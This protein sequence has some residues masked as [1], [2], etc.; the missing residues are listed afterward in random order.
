MN[1]QSTKIDLSELAWRYSGEMEVDLTTIEYSITGNDQSP[2]GAWVQSR[3]P[4]EISGDLIWSKTK[5]EVD[6]ELELLYTLGGNQAQV[7]CI[8]GKFNGS[9]IAPAMANTYSFEVSLRN[10][11]N[12]AKRAEPDNPILWRVVDD[13]QPFVDEIASPSMVDLIL[14]KD[15]ESFELEVLINEPEYLDSDTL[16][17]NWEI[18]LLGMACPQQASPRYRTNAIIGWNAI[19]QSNS[20]TCF[21]TSIRQFLKNLPQA[22]E[23]R[24]CDRI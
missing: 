22:L 2:R 5:R 15:F 21:I 11:P 7:E 20:C 3:E 23:L 16:L 24:V 1:G 6:Q 4:I 18:I 8:N 9:I 10:A 14:E 12:G 13:N 19:W 17:L